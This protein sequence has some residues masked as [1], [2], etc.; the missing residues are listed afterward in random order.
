MTDILVVGGVA[1][2][3]LIYLD[4]F[5]AQKPQTVFS[6][7]FHETIGAT[8]SGKALALNQPGM[9]VTLHGM[10]GEDR[11]GE[12][13]R[14]YL[15]QQG[16]TFLS[17]TDPAGTVRHVNL[18]NAKGE[19]ISIYV[20]TGTFEPV[21][22]LARLERLIPQQDVVI[23]NIINYCR[24]LIPTV[25][26]S[27]KKLWCDIHDYDGHNAYH[28]DF[29]QAAD[30]LFLS[31]DALP[32]YRAFMQQ[33]IDSGK[34]LVVCTHGRQGATAL[35]ADGQWLTIPALLAYPLVDSSGAGDHFFAGV[36]YGQLQG[37]DLQRSLRYGA[38]TAGLCIASPDLTAP[39]LKPER[40]AADYAKYYT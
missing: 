14:D 1:W 30:V 15:Q 38:I 32:D 22:D 7:R 3:S 27:G 37:A 36:L 40:L 18:L 33:M 28:Q 6:Q 35:T 16:I 11:Y 39:D 31:S 24:H 4:D 21:L 5:P 12:S 29:I 34:D 20:N 2:D 23:L 25:K 10:V 8:G 9:T 26:Q 13:V 17:D 19:R